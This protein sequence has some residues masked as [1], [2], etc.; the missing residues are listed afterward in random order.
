MLHKAS[1]DQT[2][3]SDYADYSNGDSMTIHLLYPVDVKSADFPSPIHGHITTRDCTRLTLSRPQI[4]Y[5]MYAF[6]DGNIIN[7]SISYI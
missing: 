7:I 6:W 1:A 5:I 3:P 4:F 2:I